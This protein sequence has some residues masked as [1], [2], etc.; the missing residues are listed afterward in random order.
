MYANRFTFLLL[1]NCSLVGILP[2]DVEHLIKEA[3]PGNNLHQAINEGFAHVQ[4]ANHSTGLPS[5]G[6]FNLWPFVASEFFRQLHFKISAHV[7]PPRLKM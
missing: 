2:D 5:G 3:T 7:R 1:S 4:V 6:N